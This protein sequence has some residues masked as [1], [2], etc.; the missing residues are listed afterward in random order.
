MAVNSIRE[1]SRMLIDEN[2]DAESNAL[3]SSRNNLQA[4]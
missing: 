3:K 2:R 1:T 4:K